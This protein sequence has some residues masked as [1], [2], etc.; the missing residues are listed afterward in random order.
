ML[1]VNILLV[2]ENKFIHSQVS[3]L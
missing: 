3:L 1:S 2:C